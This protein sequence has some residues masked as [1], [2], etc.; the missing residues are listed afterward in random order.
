MFD[1]VGSLEAVE[2]IAVGAGIREH[3]RLVKAYGGTRWRKK[4]GVAWIR[5]QDG[6]MV[7][8][9]LHWYEA[10]GVGRRELK[11]KRLLED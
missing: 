6:A 8:A 9:E 7:R 5:F 1:V 11:L 4:K 2:T 10:H 3:R